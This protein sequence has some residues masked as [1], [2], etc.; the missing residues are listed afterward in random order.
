MLHSGIAV[1][2]RKSISDRKTTMVK[3]FLLLGLT[4]N[5]GLFGKCTIGMTWMRVMMKQK[6]F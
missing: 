5:H 3:Q 2:A 6:L 4:L 1:G